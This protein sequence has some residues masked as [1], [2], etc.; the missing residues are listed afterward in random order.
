MQHASTLAAPPPIA[1]GRLAGSSDPTL[2][3]DEWN[4][5]A[6]AYVFADEFAG[7]WWLEGSLRVYLY[8]CWQTMKPGLSEPDRK[9]VP[10][11]AR[12]PQRESARDHGDQ[13]DRP[14]SDR[15]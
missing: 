13:R 5:H 12:L 4:A 14:P 11:A 8:C 9:G 3:R 10:V 1:D 6:V 15:G 2:T 7:R